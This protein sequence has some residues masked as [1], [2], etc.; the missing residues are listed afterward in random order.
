MA[1]SR[2]FSRIV[3]TRVGLVS[4]GSLLVQEMVVALGGVEAEPVGL[5]PGVLDAVV[6]AR[7]LGDFDAE[8]HRLGLCHVRS[9]HQCVRRV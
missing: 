4:S 2:R 1:V 8:P 7:H 3:L 5:Q 6:G 9:P